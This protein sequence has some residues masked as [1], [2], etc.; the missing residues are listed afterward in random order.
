MWDRGKR[1]SHKQ[2]YTGSLLHQERH[3]VPRNHW[4]IHY[5]IKTKLHTSHTKVVWPWTP[6]ETHYLWQTTPRMLILNPSRTHNTHWQHKYRNT[7]IKEEG[8][9]IQLGI[10]K[11]KVQNYNPILFHTLKNDP[12]LFQILEKLFW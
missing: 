12:K 4:V 1:E 2:I 10:T 11:L 8:N 6:Q 9:I 7:V 3:P 5:A